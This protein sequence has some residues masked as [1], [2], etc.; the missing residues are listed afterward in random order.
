MGLFLPARI[1]ADDA[2]AIVR[3]KLEWILSACTPD[4]VWLFGSAATGDMTEASDVDLA[5]VFPDDVAI[6][7]AQ[8]KLSRIPRLD[9]WPH[10]LVWF[11][12]RDFHTRKSIGGL[13]M[14]I[15]R[16]GRKL[17]PEDTP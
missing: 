6:R 2:A 17:Y 7:A 4:E 12:A 16:E 9:D 14:I 8:A 10:D 13:P 15:S 5:V 11:R 3:R 1:A